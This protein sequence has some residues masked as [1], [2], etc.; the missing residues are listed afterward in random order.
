MGSDIN[1][2]SPLGS[3]SCWPCPRDLAKDS[4]WG[5]CR[6]APRELSLSFS[7][8]R[9]GGSLLRIPHLPAAVWALWE[10]AGANQA[11]TCQALV[12]IS[13]FRAD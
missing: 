5:L 8:Q 13:V 9:G 7:F 2:W 1:C 11:L 12:L 3:R 10:V 6:E 4:C